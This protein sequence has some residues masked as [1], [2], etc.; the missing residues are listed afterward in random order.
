[1]KGYKVFNPDWTCRDFQYAVGE[2]FRHEGK[3]EVCEA[4]FHFCEKI[5]DC[6]GYYAFDSDNKVAEIEATGNVK[7]KGDKSVTDEIRIV[8]EL[9]WHEVLNLANEGKNCTGYHNTG[10]CNTGDC[11]SGY[12]NTGY[13]NTGNC[14]TGDCNSGY[15]NT[16]D[17]NTGYRNS[18]YRNSGD[19]N[20]GYRNSGDRNTGNCNSGDC[21]S[22]Y[23]NSGNYNSG[24]WNSCNYSAGFFNSVSQSVYA[25][26]KPLN[27][28]RQDFLE[29]EG[30]KILS[31]NFFLCKWISEDC[32]TEGEK[33]AYPEY[34][35]TRGYMKTLDFKTACKDMWDRLTINEKQAVREI[36]NF[37]PAVF[38]EI[39]G[40][41]VEDK[42][43]VNA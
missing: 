32:M 13:R 5:A 8:R 14:N 41:N 29:Y 40:I 31:R 2:T 20:T 6:F 17:C 33:E 16:G 18:G 10:D 24:N 37:D 35:T 30:M 34:K 39:T 11:N 15:R 42:G 22:G 28:S 27:I 23:R 38:E 21:N 4:G 9:S 1:M 43:A 7:T 26:N 36:P 25:F 19:C 12:R 3:I